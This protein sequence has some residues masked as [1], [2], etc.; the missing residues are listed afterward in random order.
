MKKLL[1]IPLL[2]LATSASAAIRLKTIEYAFV[3]STG[4]L[5]QG[6][7]HY[8]TPLGV[9]IP[10]RTNR[11]F[12]SVV[13]FVTVIDSRTHAVNPS[14]N[15]VG[16]GIDAVAYSTTSVG[17]V[18]SN[19]GESQSYLYLNDHTAYFNTN[20]TASSH[21]VYMSQLTSSSTLTNWA[22]KLIITY[23]YN[24]TDT[25]RVK[26]VFIPIE[27]STGTASESLRELGVNQIPA[28]SSYLP[29]N[30]KVFRDIFFE[31]ITNENTQS[32]VAPDPI[33]GLSLDAESSYDDGAHIDTL[34][35]ARFYRR[36]WKRTDMDTTATHAFKAKT[37]SAA[38][39][40]IPAIGAVLV[41]TYEYN[42]AIS[43]HV[44]NSLRIPMSSVQGY[45]P[46][47]G[48]NTQHI[49]ETNLL[50]DEK[51]PEIKQS[52]V[53]IKSIDAA[54]Y[55]VA[56]ATDTNFV[57][58]TTFTFAAAVNCGGY[59]LIKRIDGPGTGYTITRG[60][61]AIKVGVNSLSLAAGSRG[62]M[63]TA[64]LYINY[65][66]SR[67]YLPGGDANHYHTVATSGP[68]FAA[69]LTNS[70]HVS[71]LDI[72]E[73]NYYIGSK[74]FVATTWQAANNGYVFGVEPVSGEYK[75]ETKTEN[76]IL[77]S[78][79]EIGQ[80]MFFSDATKAYKRYPLDPDTSRKDVEVFRG[81]NYDAL[82]NHFAQYF[83]LTTYHSSTYTVTGTVSGY[84]GDGSG[85]TV[86][87]YRSD[88][89]EK[90]VSVTTAAGGTF[91]FAWYNASLPIYGTAYQDSTHKGRSGDIVAGTTAMDISFSAAAA[92]GTRSYP[93]V[94]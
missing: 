36:I 4:S 75:Q 61:N 17:T 93:F 11:S 62:T 23:E 10:E 47:T 81:V 7:T 68:V 44:F 49:F 80:V 19:T 25:T 74:G 38:G 21:T 54:A 77:S 51:D 55:S 87:A 73:T 76:H 3:Q 60:S 48:P 32:A 50:I 43:T 24:D 53:M 67:S 33:M 91:S 31:I 71:K 84:T 40:P 65:T 27:S 2:L 9:Y 30:S 52:G 86:N 88:T 58:K 85:I 12:K 15:T 37:T 35:S 63:G 41:V 39:M 78:D 70:R 82:G 79:A 90:I 29:E 42:A 46:G 14:A 56:V 89:D 69:Q 20:F 92:G 13:S 59:S 66:S 1:L 18:I 26:T 83:N 45:N 28:L 94:Q 6:A 16:I 22:S 5:A 64:M 57:R 72:P 8:F 34:V